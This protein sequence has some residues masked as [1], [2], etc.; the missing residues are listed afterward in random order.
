MRCLLELAPRLTAEQCGEAIP[1]ILPEALLA[2]KEVN[3]KTRTVAFTL[4]LTMARRMQQLGMPTPS[5]DG[6]AVRTLI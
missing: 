4:L 3:E 2:T 1:A 5:T 6:P